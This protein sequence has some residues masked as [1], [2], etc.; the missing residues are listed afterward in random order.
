M[1][2]SLIYFSPYLIMLI[3]ILILMFGEHEEDEHY[4]C[5]RFS[6]IMLLTSLVLA[7]IFY[8]KPPILGFSIGN[9]YTL[10]FECMLYS[11]SLILLYLSRKWFAAMHRPAY[12]FCG[13]LFITLLFGNLLVASIDLRL[14]SACAIML[15]F[16]NYLMLRYSDVQK[17]SNTRTRI[18]F[19]LILGGTFLLLGA[20]LY[21]WQMCGMTDYEKIRLYLEFEKDDTHT[22]ITIIMLI[23]PFLFLLGLAPLHFGQTETLSKTFLPVFTYFML[24]PTI[25]VWGGFIHLNI[26]VLPPIA[27][28][29]Q[30]F[31]VSIA[32]LSVGV[33]AIGAC[34]GQN[35][36]KIFS[37]FA[38]YGS[39]IIL[40][41]L[42]R[43]TPNA[44]NSGFVYMFVYLLAILGICSCL[45]GLKK[46]GEYLFML[47]EFE[48]AAQKRPYITAMMLV[49]M[50]SLLG[51]P[52]L[53]GFLGLFSALNYQA[54][55]HHFYQLI[56]LLIMMLVVGYAFLQIMRTLY[57]IEHKTAFDRA[58]SGIYTA[59]FLN[60][61]LMLIIVLK[62]Q[63]LAENIYQM[64]ESMFQ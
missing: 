30:T 51:M 32:L 6:R 44:L 61:I 10:I 48:G 2:E 42:R 53:S 37:Y 60:A 21:I 29:L 31:Y 24:L 9:R 56:Y 12:L 19:A 3:A 41:T 22:Y 18:Y 26:S 54:L 40:L 7:V 28:Y 49:F 45:F 11:G 8:N 16:N 38:V 43:F 4:R 58:D 5:F 62:P 1:I 64:L 34:G 23:L 63:F 46:K 14:S 35:V 57:F 55:H 50:F 20:T 13:S 59:I 47:T 33:G 15:M 25:A 52:P 27:A 36:Y 17:E 39:G